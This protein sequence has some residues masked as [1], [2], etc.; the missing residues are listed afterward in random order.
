MS[1]HLFY[2]AYGSNLHPLRLA[3][4][5]PSSRFLG[6][7]RVLGYRLCFHKCGQDGSAKCNALYTGSTGDELYGAVYRMDTGHKPILDDFE[8]QGYQADSFSVVLNKA[9]YTVFYYAAVDSYI[10]NN[11][12]PYHW[13]KELVILGAKFHNLPDK[14]LM[15]VNAVE[16]A[17]DTDHTRYH[18]HIQL[19]KRIQVFDNDKDTKRASGPAVTDT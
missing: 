8:G 2:F 17:E 3:E 12:R 10:N 18:R 13:Y 16:S 7:A 19:I 1:N 14:Y 15:Q 6:I 4:R 9:E 5:I 11:L